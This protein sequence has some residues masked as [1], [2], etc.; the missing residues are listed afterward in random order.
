MRTLLQ[1]LQYGFRQLRN[2]P[3]F[4]V[5][6]VLTLALGIGINAAMFSVVD[7]VLLRSMPFPRADEVV[8][9]AVRSESGGFG[10][11]SLPD[12]Q[13]WQARS[14]S[15]E[16]IGYYMEQ[17]PT[18]GGT[19]TPKLTVQVVSSANLFDLLGARPLMGRTFLPGDSDSG[20]TSVVILSAGDLAGV[21]PRR[22]ADHRAVGAGE[23]DSLYRDWRDA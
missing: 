20:R 7:Q 19:S 18:L 15:F 12:I 6:A 1:D 10:S 8:Q 23:R 13:D 16:K 9:M 17:I 3:V 4:A 11:T 2:A 5:T 22:P 21:V 14:H